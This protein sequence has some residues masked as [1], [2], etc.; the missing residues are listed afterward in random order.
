MAK[1]DFGQTMTELEGLDQ[2]NADLHKS[3]DYTLKSLDN[4]LFCTC[5]QGLGRLNLLP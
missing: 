3:C 2:I 1:T 4:L 5:V